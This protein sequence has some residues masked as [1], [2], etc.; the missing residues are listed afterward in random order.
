MYYHAKFGG[1]AEMSTI[2]ESSTEGSR[3]GQILTI[4]S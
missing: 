1:Y 3:I 2:D 4:L